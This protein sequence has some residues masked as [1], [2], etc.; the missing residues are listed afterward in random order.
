MRQL[1]HHERKLLRKVDL[2]SWKG[3]DNLRVAQAVFAAVEANPHSTPLQQAEAKVNV[4]KAKRA[5]PRGTYVRAALFHRLAPRLVEQD[6]LTT[7]V[8]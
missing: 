1:K 8:R 4:T 7:R 6:A 3:E 5:C 2:F